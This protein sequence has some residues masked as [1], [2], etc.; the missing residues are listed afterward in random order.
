MSLANAGDPNAKPAAAAP[1]DCRKRR[2]EVAADN[3]ASL[4]RHR[5]HM[6]FP[7]L[8]GQDTI[9]VPAKTSIRISRSANRFL[10][11][12]QEM[13]DGEIELSGVLQKRKMAGIRQD[14]QPRMRDRRGDGLGMI[15]LDGLV[16]IAVDDE[17]RRV[18]GL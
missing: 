18:D 17:D 14:Q 11:V 1:T 5:V 3:M 9:V 7:L 6:A 13:K 12:T 16:V 4:A 10:L 8:A 2:L 15:A